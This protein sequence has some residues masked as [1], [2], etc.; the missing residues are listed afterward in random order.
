MEAPGVHALRPEAHPL[1][2]LLQEVLHRSFRCT[3]VY[4]R[5]VMELPR[6]PA[7]RIGKEIQIVVSGVGRHI[8]MVRGNERHPETPSVVDAARPEHKRVYGV[9]QIRTKTPQ[10]T[11]YAGMRERELDPGVRRERYA[12]DPGYRG[13]RGG[14]GAPPRGTGGG[15]EHGIS[16]TG[17]P[18]G[19]GAQTGDDAGGRRQKRLR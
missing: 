5:P 13:P 2:T 14:G 3:Q 6:P 4:L 11:S 12:G 10:G 19:G 9:Y 8:G 18:L 1:Y 7:G 15:D 17:E 16:Y